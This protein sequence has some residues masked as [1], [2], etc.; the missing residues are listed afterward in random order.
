[1]IRIFFEIVEIMQINFIKKKY[2]FSFINFRFFYPALETVGQRVAACR[3]S[4]LRDRD[5]SAKIKFLA[6]DKC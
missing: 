5:L 1:M 4:E 6:K 3:I 2:F